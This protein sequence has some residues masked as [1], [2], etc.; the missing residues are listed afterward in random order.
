[1]NANVRRKKKG[2]TR[3]IIYI[4][5][6]IGD[7]TFS[8]IE[9]RANFTFDFDLRVFNLRGVLECGIVYNNKM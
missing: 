9:R 2:D 3:N 7:F 1:M 5:C 4:I 8:R 6:D